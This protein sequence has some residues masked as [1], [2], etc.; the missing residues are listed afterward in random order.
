[1]IN[2][3]LSEN[4]P[5]PLLGSRFGSSDVNILGLRKESELYIF[6]YD[7]ESRAEA[8]RQLGRFADNPELSFNWYDAAVL[9]QR[10]RLEAQKVQKQA[11]EAMRDNRQWPTFD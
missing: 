8:L 2:S 11:Q 6:L 4:S 10:I 1:M 3:P 9:S 5:F 7:N